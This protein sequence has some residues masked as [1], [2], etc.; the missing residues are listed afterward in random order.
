MSG[1]R[2]YFSYQVSLEL[3]K[4]D[5]EGAVE[6]ERGGDWRNDL[7]NQTVQVCVGWALD[8]QVSA[9]DIVDSLKI[10]I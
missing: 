4:I 9:A 7:T 1:T 10:V 3:S 2:N 5:I 6:S 8:V